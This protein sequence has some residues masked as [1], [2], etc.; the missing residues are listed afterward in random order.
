MI[1]SRNLENLNTTVF[2]NKIGN[3]SFGD[4]TTQPNEKVV[5][6]IIDK[7]LKECENECNYFYKKYKYTLDTEDDKYIYFYL[8]VQDNLFHC[9]HDDYI[10]LDIQE[11]DE[12]IVIQSNSIKKNEFVNEMNSPTPTIAN[13]VNKSKTKTK[14]EEF[15]W[16]QYIKNYDDLMNN[17]ELNTKEKAWQHWI[18]YG[19]KEGRTFNRKSI[20]EK[21]NIN[22]FDWKKYIDTYIDLKRGDIRTKEKAWE[23]WINHGRLEGRTYFTLTNT[24]NINV[25]NMYEKSLPIETYKTTYNREENDFNRYGK[26]EYLDNYY[27]AQDY[28]AQDYDGEDYDGEKYPSTFH[29][30]KNNYDMDPLFDWITYIKSNNE[31]QK[32]II[33]T[34]EK[35]WLH[36]I[37]QGKNEGRLYYSLYDERFQWNY[38]L[39]NNYDL[40]KDGI[41]TKEKAWHHWINYGKYEN[42]KHMFLSDTLNT[43]PETK[44]LMYDEPPRKNIVPDKKKEPITYENF[45]WENYIHNYEDLLEN[46][47]TTKKQAWKHWIQF[48]KPEGRTTENIDQ[49]E[50]EQYNLSDKLINY[51]NIFFKEKYIN[52]G[53]HFYG[54]KWVIQSFIENHRQNN[55]TTNYKYPLFFDEWIEKLLLWGNKILNK[56]HIETIKKNKYKMV[57]FIHNPPFLQWYDTN[58]KSELQKEI[59]I[60]DERQLNEYTFSK[61]KEHNLTNNI[62]FLYTLSN[63]HKEYIYNNYPKFRNKVVSVYHPIE[64]N[65]TNGFQ[66]NSFLKNKKIYHI[67]WWLRNFKTFIECKLPDNFSKHILIKNDFLTAWKNNIVPNYDLTNIQVINELSNDK[68]SKI[69]QNGCIFVDIVDCVANNTILECI[70]FNT[71]IITRRTPSAEE[72][73]GK[74]YPLFFNNV[75]DLS[76]LSQEVFLLHLIMDAH[77]Y[78]KSLDKSRIMLETF[79]RKINYDLNKLTIPHSNIQLTWCCLITYENQ[80]YIDKLIDFFINQECA[81]KIQLILFIENGQEE[82]IDEI[83]EFIQM[84]NNI[85]YVILPETNNLHIDFYNH[86]V[87]YVTTDFMTIV[88]VNDQ[89]NIEFSSQYIHYLNNYPTCDV[90]FSSY[91]IIH[92]KNNSSILNKFTKDGI[93]FKSNF[94]DFSF[95]TSG[96]V[97]RKS[98]HNII[99]IFDNHSKNIIHDFLK[100]CINHHL[101]IMCIS[102]QSLYSIS[103]YTF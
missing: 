98:L 87:Q 1:K 63:T 103:S 74:N 35:A 96:I 58:N 83:E 46:N 60:S 88:N 52:Y 8:K 75:E 44:K 32:N 21:D 5:H 79:N 51:N 82:I 36:W 11:P 86:C 71:P 38:Y 55:T 84:Y 19:Q 69:F 31:L 101:N 41:D 43:L 3:T 49:Q 72:Y 24:N 97:W 94:Y 77:K 33:N 59:L 57:T 81:E 70:S 7:S 22:N 65:E 102:E 48:G 45:H 29:Q 66:M 2:P 42:R 78:L 40:I 16:K 91:T 92:H 93:L 73:L 23:H 95:P 18:Q 53:V 39:Q 85:H 47:V 56:K 13:H 20:S 25:D 15:N 68:Y 62:L 10:Y 37:T 54:W 12:K 50:I 89:Y 90:A 27:D 28:D 6:S 99:G 67:G 9:Y 14:N 100:K 30:N 26:D 34:K 61:I 4:N 64:V 17:P 76:F 80:L